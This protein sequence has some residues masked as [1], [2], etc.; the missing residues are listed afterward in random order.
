VCAVHGE[1]VPSFGVTVTV[2]VRWLPSKDTVHVSIPT[3]GELAVN[4]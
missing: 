3:S 4:V 1:Q 2:T